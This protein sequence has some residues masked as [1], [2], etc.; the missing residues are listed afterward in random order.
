MRWTEG[1]SV[2][3]RPGEYEVAKVMTENRREGDG[4]RFRKRKDVK[5]FC[6]KAVCNVLMAIHEACVI[7]IEGGK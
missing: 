1:I 5:G 7:A 4:S 2:D 3:S 6:P